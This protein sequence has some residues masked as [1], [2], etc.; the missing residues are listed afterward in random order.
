MVRKISV[1]LGLM[2]FVWSSAQEFQIKQDDDDILFFNESEQTYEIWLRVQGTAYNEIVLPGQMKKIINSS[3]LTKEDLRNS[4]I[5]QAY[6]YRALA[7]DV[8][9][10]LDGFYDRLDKSRKLLNR[11]SK[12]VNQPFYRMDVFDEFLELE[13]QKQQKQNLKS[14]QLENF[15]ASSVLPKSKN[16][17]AKTNRDNSKSQKELLSVVS[18]FVATKVKHEGELPAF[19]EEMNKIE[20]LFYQ[21]LNEDNQTQ[22]LGSLEDND[23]KLFTNNPGT[24]LGVY[25]TTNS[26]GKIERYDYPE[27]DTR[28]F[29]FEVFASQR[30]HQMRVSKRR[31]LNYHAAASYLSLKDK[32]FDL[33]K[34]FLTF[35][36]QVRYTGYY[37]NQVALIGEGGLLMDI[38]ADKYMMPK[39][40]KQFGYYLGGEISLLFVRIGV[41]YYDRL[42]EPE[43]SPEGKLFYRLGLVAKF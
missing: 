9:L 21:Y 25:I 32:G 15:V 20:T 37:E 40:K 39:D 13:E 33:K 24:E 11:G 38:T 6:S 31:T 26:F 29:N 30:F 8:L 18:K 1:V 23:F 22:E 17:M 10:S 41:R 28:G 12:E 42:T 34:S 35:G 5:I 4:E 7:Q 16:L 19:L 43:L 2:L 36:P 14:S 3:H 27:M